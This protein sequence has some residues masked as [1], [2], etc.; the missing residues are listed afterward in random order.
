MKLWRLL[1]VLLKQTWRDPV[2][3]ALSIITAPL[4]VVLYWAAL[5]DSIARQTL[6]VTA[7]ESEAASLDELVS[8]IN[9]MPGAEQVL[10]RNAADEDDVVNQIKRGR[11]QVGLVLLGGFTQRHDAADT[12]PTAR[13]IGDASAAAY[14]LLGQVAREAV[15]GVVRRRSGAPPPVRFDHV[16]VGLSGSVTAF[17]AYVPGLLVF[18]VIMLV[19]GSSMTV[20][21]GREAGTLGR[22]LLTPVPAPVVLLGVSLCHLLLGALSVGLTLLTAHLLGFQS[23]GSIGLA[24]LVCIIACMASIGIGMIVASLSRTQARSLLISCVA[25]FLLVLFSGIIFPRPELLVTVSDGLQV[26]LF[27]LLPTVPLVKALHSIL[28]LGGSLGEVWIEAV[29]L[30]AI[31]LVTFILGCA[32]F[33]RTSAPTSYAWE[34]MP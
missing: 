1:L 20:A 9:G 13:I 22:L 19:F 23:R 4:F 30:V 25:M 26:D 17:E 24:F 7:P 28:I 33:V 12:M 8:F 2:S 11:A 31:S 14:P 5:G 16:A 3:A 18:S 34:G 6:L 27:G 15:R 29:T 32:L 21:R 10:V